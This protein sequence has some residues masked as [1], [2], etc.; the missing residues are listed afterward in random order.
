MKMRGFTLI[1]VLI[2]LTV[3]AILASITSSAMYQAFNTRDRVTSQANRLNTLQL[4]IILIKRDTQQ[5]LERSILGDEMHTFPPFTGQPNYIEFTRGGVANPMGINRGSTL[6][7]VAY[8]CKKNQLIRRSWQT[9]DSP[10]RN[11][12][13][14]KLLLDNL[15][16]CEFSFLA[17]NLQILP[18]WQE[19]ALQQNQRK[20]TLPT[21]IRLT[22]VLTDWGK[23]S[24]QFIVP[25]ALYAEG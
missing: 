9:L 4:A 11:Q 23:M 13:Q 15:T 12:Y 19:Y 8:L 3:F 25:E 24:M 6:Q 2:A 7:R 5:I 21:A 1:E 16:Q 22:L 14:D 20:E 17:H 10:N 18:S